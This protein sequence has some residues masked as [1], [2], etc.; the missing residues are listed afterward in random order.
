[1]GDAKVVRHDCRDIFRAF[2]MAFDPKKMFLGYAG[3]LASVAWCVVVVTFFSALKLISTTPD[4]FIKLI[5]YSAKEDISILINSLLSVIMPLDFGEIFVIS[6]LIFGLLAI[7]S[8]VGGAIT[9]IAPWTMPGMKVFVW[10]MPEVRQEKTLVLF[11]VAT[12]ASYWRFLLCR[13]QRGWWSDRTD[14]CFG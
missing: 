3:L 8:F 11:L 14:S 12:G 7:W 10:Q 9:R 6:I 13:V 4:I 5:F 1:M 2:K